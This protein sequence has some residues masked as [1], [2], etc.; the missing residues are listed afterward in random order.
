MKSF[1]SLLGYYR[2]FAKDFDKITRS[3]TLYLKKNVKVIQEQSFIESFNIC[4]MLLCNDPIL[5]H[6]DIEKEFIFTTD[7]S[8]V[9]VRATLPQGIIRPKKP[10]AYASRT[11]LYYNRKRTFGR[12]LGM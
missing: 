5:Q 3:L 1:L 6:P 4:K 9:E 8:N 10:V 11:T 12:Y 2:R 7:V